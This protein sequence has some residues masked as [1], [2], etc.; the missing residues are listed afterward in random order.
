MVCL[1][2]LTPDEFAHWY[3]HL[4]RLRLFWAKPV[5]ELFPLYRLVE[6][7]V[8]KVR[9]SSEKPRLEEAY[10]IIL[11][12]AKKLD[13][14]AALRGTK[15]LITP[16]QVEKSL[17]QARGGLYIYSASRPCATGLYLEKP[18]EGHPEP[19]PDHV[20]L[21][22]G[23]DMKYLLY[24]NRWNFNIDYLWLS[25]PEHLDEAVE[26]AICEARRLGGRYVTIATGDGHLG[27]I[28]H[29]AYRPDHLYNTYKLGF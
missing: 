15:I 23:P 8:V 21:Y 12:R 16:E 4:G 24:L 13:F 11:R 1:E 17:Y 3:R 2:P 18:P 22:S 26:S 6:G 9:W 27:L 25:G 19:G 10:L 14:A 5:V 29:S 20:L 28:D 7:C